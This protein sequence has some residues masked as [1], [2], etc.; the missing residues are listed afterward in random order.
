MMNEKGFAVTSLLYGAIALILI[1]FVVVIS[2]MST[3]KDLNG[4][5][6]DD[7]ERSLNGYLDIY[8]ESISP[9]VPELVGDMIPVVFDGNT[10]VK[11]DV[12]NALNSWYDYEE[13]RWANVV[14]VSAASRNS[15]KSAGV[16]TAI[17]MGD[18][19]AMFVWIPRYSYT[20][21]NGIGVSGHGGSTASISTPGAFDI[22]WVDNTV[23]DT[24]SASYTGNSPSNWF[25]PPGF[26]FGNSCDNPSTR[27]SSS[28]R[29]LNGIWVGK[30][31]T[32]VYDSDVNNLTNCNET[33]TVA[34]CNSILPPTI[35]PDITSWRNS[36]LINYHNSIKTY[37]SGSNGTS[38]HGF[39]GSTYDAHLMK[40][41]EWAVISYLSQSRYGKYGNEIYHGANKEVAINNC[42]LYITGV[43]GDSVSSP[44][45][46]E[47]CSS[48]TYN[49]EKGQTASTTGNTTGVYDMSGGS[50]EWIMGNMKNTSGGFNPS[51]SGFSTLEAKYYNLYNRAS[52]FNDYSNFI[53]GDATKDVV[54]FYNDHA[55]MLNGSYE[56][57]WMIRGGHYY[58]GAING[59]FNFYYAEGI[60]PIPSGGVFENVGVRISLVPNK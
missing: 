43:G 9:Q 54:G 3:T 53:K 59:V 48:N 41:T 56:S 11:A 4:N 47:S 57:P 29:E 45:S 13:Q 10:W 19:S 50:F 26:C 28:N 42:N 5:F 27:S 40:N 21:Y 16:G 14:T 24:G 49:T 39:T 15:Y 33:N 38:H 22:K 52:R 36:S 46:S 6:V 25:T 31:E 60:H 18:I 35:K 17:S 1:L 12:S 20:L 23:V 51:A 55:L 32:S 44:A 2:I 8:N 7:V 30:F 37:M 34:N 58:L